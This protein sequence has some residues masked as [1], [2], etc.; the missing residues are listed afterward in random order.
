MQFQT[1]T[2]YRLCSSK[3]ETILIFSV[4]V[5]NQVL[6]K[7][8]HILKNGAFK[9]LKQQNPLVKQNMT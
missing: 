6:M 1:E 9:C 3:R 2:Q 5:V 4:E 8:Q 7:E